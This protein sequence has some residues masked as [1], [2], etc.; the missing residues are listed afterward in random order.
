MTMTIEQKLDHYRLTGERVEVTW[1][2]GY[3]DFTGYGA[4]TEGRKARFYVGRSTGREPCLLQIYRRDS[5]GGQA[6]SID[7]IESIR[8]LGIFIS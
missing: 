6:V 1:R 2:A 4:S 5:L 7:L 3:E 8:G